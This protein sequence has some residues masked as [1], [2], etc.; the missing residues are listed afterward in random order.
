MIADDMGLRDDADEL[1]AF[2]VAEIL[3]R[4]LIVL[5]EFYESLAYP[6]GAIEMLA[7]RPSIEAITDGAG[8]SL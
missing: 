1:G 2:D 3:N 4:E 8:A 5:R 7:M 6:A